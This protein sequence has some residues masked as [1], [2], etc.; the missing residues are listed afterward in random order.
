MANV[1][2]K[3]LN[4]NFFSISKY[5]DFYNIFTCI[6]GRYQFNINPSRLRYSIPDYTSL[7]AGCYQKIR[8]KALTRAEIMHFFNPVF[9]GKV[10]KCKVRLP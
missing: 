1:R 9:R 5:L 8:L 4:S 10:I 2:T 7:S 3:A 6:I